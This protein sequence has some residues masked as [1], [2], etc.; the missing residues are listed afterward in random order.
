MA[1][2]HLFVW[3][4]GLSIGV[5]AA[6]LG[7]VAILSSPVERSVHQKILISRTLPM[8][9]QH[10][11]SNTFQAKALIAQRNEAFKK[12]ISTV[13]EQEKVRRLNVSVPVQFQGKTIREVKLNSFPKAL[14]SGA[15]YQPI[16]QSV[17]AKPIAQSAV[18]KPIALT[19]DDGPWPNTTSQV[20]TILK[21]NNVKATFFVVGK[22]VQQYPQ[23]VK[24]IVA[25]GHALANHSWSHQYHHYSQA[26]AA[27]EIDR[28]ADLVYKT[29]GVK[30]SL[31]R[32]PAGILNNG[33]VSYA[34]QKKYAVIMW[35]ADSNDWRSRRITT[36]AFVDNLLKQ[37]KPGGI[38]LLHDGG[39]DRSKTI[40]ALPQLIAQLKKRGYKFV[41]VPELLEMGNK[42]LKASKR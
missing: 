9:Q 31:F 12:A 23:V 3:Q 21:K 26:A 2:R 36:Q 22:Q 17:P 28:T 13:A 25:G 29:T 11:D 41:T 33:L 32:P 24:Q 38:I 35:S 34:H 39:G 18:A 4:R 1:D 7:F 19:F 8:L 27:S 20:I 16:A 6:A 5:V 42:E 10:P 15:P 14:A 40:H 30:I 37:A